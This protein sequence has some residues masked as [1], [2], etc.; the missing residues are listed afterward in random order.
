MQFLLFRCRAKIL[1]RSG[2]TIFVAPE[3]IFERR[4]MKNACFSLC[5]RHCD[6]CGRRRGRFDGGSGRHA[7]SLGAPGCRAIGPQG[8]ACHAPCGKYHVQP[9]RM[10]K[11]PASEKPALFHFLPDRQHFAG[12]EG[13][14]AAVSRFGNR[15]AV[16]HLE[17]GGLG[18]VR[19][20]ADERLHLR[21]ERLVPTAHKVRIVFLA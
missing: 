14:L 17:V 4:R 18:A 3:R 11:G 12:L 16:L 19:D 20:V 5:F 10:K 9:N 15:R 6:R 13:L 8:R 21:D 1:R 7:Q 2:Q